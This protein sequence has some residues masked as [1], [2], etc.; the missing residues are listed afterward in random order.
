MQYIPGLGLD[1]VLAELKRLR[2]GAPEGS[3]VERQNGAERPVA[4][5]GVTAEEIARSLWTG[6]FLPPAEDQASEPEPAVEATTTPTV[7]AATED[8][9]PAQ[10]PEAG[11]RSDPF[12]LSS[13][14]V[15]LPGSGSGGRAGKKRPTYWQ[16]VARI[17]VQVAD[18]LQHAH[19][20]GV[21]HRDIKPSNL[22]LD[23]TGVV[24][25]TDFGLAKADDQ[26]NLT[27]TGDILGTLRYMA[28]EAFEARTDARADVYSLG[29]TLYEL[30]AMR[31]AFDEQDRNRL[32]K[33][34]TTSE[35]ARL[36]RLNPEVPHDLVTIVHKAIE[37]DPAHRY[38]TAGALLA[39]LQRFRDDEPIQAR[40]HTQWEHCRRW[41]RRN[42]V[43]AGLT[44][45]V[46]PL[47]VTAALVATVAAIRFEKLAFKERVANAEAGLAQRQADINLAEAR[48]QRARA[49][50]KVESLR[51]Q[52][53]I[54]RVNLAYRETLDNNVARAL[55]LLEGCP[56]DLR[57]W[58]W[59]YAS[60]QCHLDLHT[61]REPAPSVNC[62]AFSPDGM[63]VASGSGSFF[64]NEGTGDLVVRDV[65]TGREVFAQRGLP[66]GLR[67]VAFSPNG[68]WL[69]SG[70]AAD[71]VVWDA[72]TGQM[73][74][75]KRS[76]PLPILSLAFSPDGAR[77]VAGY[78]RF[79][80]A[81]G[82][83]HAKVWDATTGNLLIDRL[84]GHVG[85]NWSVAFSPDGRQVALTSEGLVDV[86]DLATRKPI[87]TLRG[88][89]SLVN[90]VAFSP[91]GRY[92]ASGGI[93]RTIKLWAR[94]SGELVRTFLGHEGYI[95]GLAF[96]P[97]SRRIVSASE[98]MSVKLWQVS[99]DRELATFHGHTHFVN[100]V[101][102]SPDGQHVASGG[103]DQTV[104]LWFATPNLQLIFPGNNGWFACLAFSP[105]GRQVAS[106]S[107]F[108]SKGETLRLWNST[109]GEPLL[110]F[111]ANTAWTNAVAFS[112]DG[113]LLASA[114]SDRIV[115]VADAITG[116]NILYLQGH[117]DGVNA[118]AFSPDGRLLVSGSDDHMVKLWEIK[119][120]RG[121]LTF[122]GHDDGVAAV[123]FSPDGRQ[124][125][126]G[127][128]DKT[129]RVW[130]TTTGRVNQIL[131]GHTAGVRCVAFRPDGAQLASAGGLWVSRSAEVNEVKIWDP[132]SGQEL[133]SLRGHTSIVLAA[134]F[135][136][137]GRRLAT[138]SDDRTIKLWDTA[139]GLEVFTLRGHTSGV[140]SV[141]FSPD[142]QRLASGSIDCTARFWDLSPITAD[143]MI[144]RKAVA[145]GQAQP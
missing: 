41:A 103:L 27:H 105:D 107:S 69:A 136:P 43:V 50:E 101:A 57:G 35:P 36:E 6:R 68:R 61:F 10:A 34:V 114:G 14:S 48:Q 51:R 90:S 15:V 109:T 144:R 31:P 24:W 140:L 89:A 131:Q 93:D 96:S 29:L 142:G 122:Q 67:A 112:P 47:L 44:L 99:S 82:T 138:A 129:V 76:G 33:Q 71:L 104:K 121:I 59:S 128:G 126:S 91:D 143:V 63:R 85:G 39:D 8:I 139:R 98:D 17:G 7:S 4:P 40:R 134:A 3:G 72:H 95:R 9:P 37:H 80:A 20:L 42:P 28:P 111:P 46:F 23:T 81:N 25:V 26:P 52:D 62:V 97:D 56:A 84:P 75:R 54:G 133:H 45:T 70:N 18:A 55:E 58:E 88:H 94:T 120:G 5:R 66:G 92:I 74:F 79:N 106:G 30:L 100:C 108:Y 21:L 78:G 12:A 60:R 117:T 53:Y 49:E 130:D 2:A 77:I 124:I 119:A 64:A 137:D 115:R 102:F 145:A 32:I 1:V 65:A 132:A 16:S 141:A 113:K 125:A 22:L 83:G 73:R 19:S 13:S 127:S 87:Q 135:S 38:P 116:R 118:V 110:S 11:R 86:W 123:A